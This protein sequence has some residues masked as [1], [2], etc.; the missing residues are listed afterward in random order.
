MRRHWSQ[1]SFRQKRKHTEQSQVGILSG[2]DTRRL[3]VEHFYVGSRWSTAVS[4]TWYRMVMPKSTPSEEPK[5]DD[6]KPEEPKS[7]GKK[8]NEG[9]E[10]PKSDGKKP[11]EKPEESK[12]NGSKKA[13]EPKPPKSKPAKPAKPKAAKPK[14]MR[15]RVGK[16]KEQPPKVDM[17]KLLIALSKFPPGAN[18]L[19]LASETGYSEARIHEC[20]SRLTR[21]HGKDNKEPAKVRRHGAL[22]QLTPVGVKF[23]LHDRYP[24][25]VKKPEK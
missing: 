8:L 15:P 21:G 20:L 19:M 13:E 11:D 3:M 1:G 17:K 24:I 6:K 14:A 5:P 10:E 22:Y 16:S 2:V 18:G 9:P 25:P 7:D 23:A 12:S 4:R